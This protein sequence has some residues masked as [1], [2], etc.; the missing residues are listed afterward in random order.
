MNGENAPEKSI[1][2]PKPS[3]WDRRDRRQSRDGKRWASWEAS[4]FQSEIV[5]Y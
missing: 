3:R 5:F 1:R 4:E 2:I